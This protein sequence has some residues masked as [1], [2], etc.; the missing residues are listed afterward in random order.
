MEVITG[1]NSPRPTWCPC[2]SLQSLAEKA[3]S[4]SWLFLFL[5]GPG[6]PASIS[7]PSNWLLLSSLTYQLLLLHMLHGVSD[8]M[9]SQS[10]LESTTEPSTFCLELKKQED[11]DSITWVSCDLDMTIVVGWTVAREALLMLMT[12]LLENIHVGEA[13]VTSPFTVGIQLVG[14][15]AMNDRKVCVYPSD[16]EDSG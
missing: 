1:S 15:T 2:S 13:A 3:L 10:T 9:V 16:V 5:L 6:N 14:K 4:L 8:L 12:E 11:N 7:P